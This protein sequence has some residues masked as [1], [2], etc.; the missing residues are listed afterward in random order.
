MKILTII[1]SF[2]LVLFSILINIRVVA[3]ASPTFVVILSFA[4]TLMAIAI[5]CLALYQYFQQHSCHY[6]D[7]DDYD[8]DYAYDD[9]YDGSMVGLD[10]IIIQSNG[11]PVRFDD[12]RIMVYGDLSEAKDDLF[13]TDIGLVRIVSYQMPDGVKEGSVFF[14]DEYIGSFSYTEDENSDDFQ[15]ELD[16]FLRICTFEKYKPESAVKEDIRSQISAYLMHTAESKAMSMD[17]IIGEDDAVGLS[18]LEMPHV[19]SG[20][21][22]G[23]GIIWFRIYGYSEPVE[24]DTLTLSDVK[25]ILEFFKNR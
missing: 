10:W 12:G 20:F 14:G 11:E 6:N 1:Y 18:T 13:G 9:D 25:N 2:L 17:V 19:T 23:E 16:L 22:D 4:I 3:L 15:K 7:D 21:Q 8:D 5:L 24:F